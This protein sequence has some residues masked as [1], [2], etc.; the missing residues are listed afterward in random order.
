MNKI[1]K[2][3]NNWRGPTMAPALNS[4]AL[5]VDATRRL[6]AWVPI[7]AALLL[8][9]V[10]TFI[11]LF[12]GIWQTD[13]NAHGPIVLAVSIWFMGFRIR[14][15]LSA[16]QI[17]YQPAPVAGWCLLGFGLAIYVLGRSQSLLLL[18]VG[19][20]LP[21]IAGCLVMF[22]GIRSLTKLW[23]AFF[24]MLFFIPLPATLIDAL[25]Q[26]LKI[27]V[28]FT[29]EHILYW[30]GYPIARNGVVL[31]IGQYQL[32][33]ADA[34]AG[35]NSLF[36]LESL[37]LLY[38]NLV[39]HQSLARNAVLA[40]LIV[41]ISFASNVLRVITLTLITYYMGDAAGQG[42]LHG[43]AGMM[44]FLSAL[45]M[46]IG[47]DTLL[48]VFFDQKRVIKTAPSQDGQGVA[49]VSPN[50]TA[51]ADGPRAELVSGVKFYSALGIYFRPAVAV[52]S[53]MVIAF[54]SA[55]LLTPVLSVEARVPDFEKMVPKQFGE[56]K[57]ISSPY[58]Q[59]DL[60]AGGV[61]QDGGELTDEKPYD[62]VLM[63]T[64]ANEKGDQV[65]LALAY[66]RE[67]RQ[68]VKIH[69]PEVCYTSQGFTVVADDPVELRILPGKPIPGM[70]LLA[71]NRQ[72][73]EAV[74]YWIR[75]GDNYSRNTSQSRWHIF[76]A[77]MKGKVPDGILVRASTVQNAISGAD[78]AYK[79][80]EAFLG[81]LVGALSPD[82]AR[83]LVSESWQRAPEE[84]VARARE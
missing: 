69:R 66:A 18:E 38:M 46:I 19:S 8:I 74:S 14:Q 37:G 61:G 31:S 52:A 43:F 62:A 7:V 34:C 64:Y 68:E 2:G 75:I 21:L 82:A 1:D 72:R 53:A 33:V 70:Q 22:F 36:T 51:I 17:S 16:R 44:L 79:V 11:G 28:S 9:C 76:R 10:P 42:F 32:L 63:R 35:L 13:R 67:Q 24:F 57:E 54:A 84:K 71:R 4:Q 25:T 30:L 80:Q 29:T 23:F 65:M 41:P 56:W 12:N 15:L 81:N 83:F 48:G 6:V 78:I 40:V 73:V 27:G 20:F 39:G 49:H 47:V 55:Y 58:I 77:G 50:P 26:P 60:T 45:L 59:M 5:A 3:R